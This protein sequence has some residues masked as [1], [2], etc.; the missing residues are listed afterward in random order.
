MTA[1]NGIVD[2]SNLIMTAYNGT[3]TTKGRL[4]L[5]D[6]AK[7]PFD[8]AL[9]IKG[10]ESNGLLSNFTSFSKNIS[11][12][13][14]MTTH[15]KGDLNDTLGIIH[16]TLLGNGGA[17]ISEGKLIG[18]PLTAKIADLTG[19]EAMRQLDFKDWNNSFTIENG[20]ITIKDLT[21]HSSVSDFTV[22]GSQ[23]LDG[24]MD[25]TVNVK[26]PAAYTSQLKLQGVGDQLLQ[27]FKDKDGR[28]NLNLGVTG[29]R[30][31]PSVKLD[32]RAQE[33]MA[34]KAIQDKATDILKGKTDDLKKKAE[35]GLKKFFKRPN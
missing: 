33:D 19:I 4:D 27:F 28:V 20:R 31:N 23:G 24:S 10:V 35:D 5:R 3:I 22:G 13:V 18:F 34:K 8:F 26:V 25:Y 11:G 32:T 12:K 7:R 30:D 16:P 21:I 14:T 15:L 9:D 2:L 6:T 1:S 29:T 17:N